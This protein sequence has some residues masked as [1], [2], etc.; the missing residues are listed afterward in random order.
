M[1]DI[2]LRS[3]NLSLS[4]ACACRCIF[5]PQ[6]RGRPGMPRHMPLP[7]AGSVIL[8]ARDAGVRAFSLGENGD[9]LMNPDFLTI[10]RELRRHIPDASTVLFTN[11]VGMSEGIARAVLDEGLINRFTVNLDGVWTYETVKGVPYE[12]AANNLMKWLEIRGD[13]PVPL[14][15]QILSAYRYRNAME[16]LFGVAPAG[17]PDVPDESFRVV[18]QWT[19]RIRAGQD[20]IV[21]SP[22]FGWAHRNLATGDQ[23]RFGCPQLER[24]MHDAFVAPN[25]DWY[26][27][28]MMPEQNI[29][30]GNVVEEGLSA[31]AASA[32]RRQLIEQIAS[33]NWQA[34]GPPCDTAQA[35][36][37]IP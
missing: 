26:L 24:L 16:T 25:G 11:F 14:T 3:V 32:R 19:P 34:V 9:A 2:D 35:C 7:I 29:C 36:Q 10:C 17:L 12:R 33:R 27:C 20:H 4:N 8:Q 37:W 13:R 18:D 22:A 6:T 1:S 15:I 21:N 23:R 31:L 5:C 28:C 30:V